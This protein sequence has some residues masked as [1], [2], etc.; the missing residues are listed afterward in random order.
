MHS[1]TP[2][3]PKVG[4]ACS[5]PGSFITD[6]TFL[7][8]RARTCR[9]HA[10]RIHA[11]LHLYQCDGPVTPDV[12]RNWQKYGCLAGFGAGAQRAESVTTIRGSMAAVAKTRLLRHCHWS[13]LFRH[14]ILS[15]RGVSYVPWVAPHSR[16]ARDLRSATRGLSCTCS[17][18]NETGRAAVQERSAGEPSAGAGR[19]CS[20]AASTPCRHEGA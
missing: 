1:H 14:R 13:V 12:F 5:A 4:A 6:N 2:L 15:F 17:E 8:L 16:I 11:V 20:K 7:C 19:P 3:P 10:P 18:G 9:F